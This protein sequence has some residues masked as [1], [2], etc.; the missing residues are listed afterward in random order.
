MDLTEKK[1][2]SLGT[3]PLSLYLFTTKQNQNVFACS[4]RPTVI[5]S[6]NG[7]LAYAQVNVRVSF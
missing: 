1:Q 2:V 6:T 3:Q 4:D 5:Y 7:K